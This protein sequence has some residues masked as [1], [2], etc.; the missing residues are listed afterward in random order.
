MPLLCEK[1][2]NQFSCESVSS[3]PLFLAGL[4]HKTDGHLKRLPDEIR[5]HT[6]YNNNKF[7]KVLMFETMV[8]LSVM[9]QLRSDPIQ[10]F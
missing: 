7:L 10:N 8:C 6:I 1:V 9:E 5:V 4:A 3:A 2:V